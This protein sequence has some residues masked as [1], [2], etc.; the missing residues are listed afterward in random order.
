M[1]S[2]DPAV[3]FHD[4]S[5]HIDDEELLEEA[6]RLEPALLHDESRIGAAI[7][8]I[9]VSAIAGAVSGFTFS[10][11]VR[12]SWSIFVAYLAAGALVLG[13]LKPLST[14]LVGPMIVW[15]AGVAFV[16]SI[17]LAFIAVSGSRIDTSGSSTPRS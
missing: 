13:L 3:W 8:T 12:S 4:L 11:E 2:R 17:V 14:R 5:V 6:A 7:W 16:W 15:P 10:D 1:P 9:L